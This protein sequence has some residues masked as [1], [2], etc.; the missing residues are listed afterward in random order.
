MR[1]RETFLAGVL[2]VPLVVGA[3]LAADTGNQSLVNAAKQGDRAAVQFM[4]N[5]PAKKDVVSAQGGA[6]LIWAASRNDVA[7]VDLLLGAGADPKCPSED[8]L[9]PLNHLDSM[10]PILIRGRGFH[11]GRTRTGRSTTAI[12]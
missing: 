2:S 6:A 3:A 9:S 4:L 11:C 5:G 8:F 7:M 1:I 12:T 10:E